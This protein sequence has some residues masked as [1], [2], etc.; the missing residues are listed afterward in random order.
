MST[1]RSA[2]RMSQGCA[3]GGG[4]LGARVEPLRNLLPG[5]PD[6]QAVWR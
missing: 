3:L 6:R 5:S 4:N 2:E 1:L